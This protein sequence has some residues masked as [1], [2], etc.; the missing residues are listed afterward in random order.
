MTLEKQVHDMEMRLRKLEKA[1]K[2]LEQEK[3]NIIQKLKQDQEYENENYNYFL[4]KITS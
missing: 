4:N 1:V 3:S 2:V